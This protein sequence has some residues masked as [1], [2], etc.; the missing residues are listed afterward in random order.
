MSRKMSRGQ[1]LGVLAGLV[2][3]IAVPYAK[4]KSAVEV[5]APADTSAA[6]KC[7]IW[8]DVRLRYFGLHATGNRYWMS[9][10]DGLSES[11][12]VRVRMSADGRSVQV[13]SVHSGRLEFDTG[14]VPWVGDGEYAGTMTDGRTGATSAVTVRVELPPLQ[15]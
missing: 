10:W 9:G 12:S 14:T 11:G 7:P 13:K 15:D 2:C 4:M 6:V 1:M 8:G 5:L 3:V